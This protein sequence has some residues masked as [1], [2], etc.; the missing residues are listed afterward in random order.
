MKKWISLCLLAVCLLTIPTL[1]EVIWEPES[2]CYA[3]RRGSC[4][5]ERRG[6]WARWAW[7]GAGCCFCGWR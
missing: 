4:G 7:A 1:A 5:R 6:Y 3:L 2:S